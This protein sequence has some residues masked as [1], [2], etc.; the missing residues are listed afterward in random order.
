MHP[1]CSMKP[2]PMVIIF[3]MSF[4]TTA[5]KNSRT[6]PPHKNRIMS[7]PGVLSDSPVISAR[8]L[9][10]VAQCRTIAAN[11][12]SVSAESFARLLLRNSRMA[13]MVMGNLKGMITLRRKCDDQFYQFWAFSNP[14]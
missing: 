12:P 11:Q 7:R 8:K 2:N 5:R 4:N 3:S 6:N 10:K 9:G 1:A 14:G 13:T